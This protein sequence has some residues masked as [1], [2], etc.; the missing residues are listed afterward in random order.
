M[1]QAKA[2][3]MFVRFSPFAILN[4]GVRPVCLGALGDSTIPQPPHTALPARLLSYRTDLLLQRGH[5]R[6]MRQTGYR[7]LD[8]QVKYIA[9]KESQGDLGKPSQSAGQWPCDRGAGQG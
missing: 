4:V 2:F 8:V 3:L 7:N 1:S 9:M 6:A 5:R